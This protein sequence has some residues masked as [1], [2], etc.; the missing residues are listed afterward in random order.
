MGLK[1]FHKMKTKTVV[2]T[3]Q[4]LRLLPSVSTNFGGDLPPESILVKN[5]LEEMM[6]SMTTLTSLVNQ[7]E[8]PKQSEAAAFISS[9][10][11]SMQPFLK[12]LKEVLAVFRSKRKITLADGGALTTPPT[13]VPGVPGLLP[14]QVL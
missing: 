9:C 11:E 8:N 14:I 5:I 3:L 4:S 6:S 12:I 10:P 2:N 7:L 13:G 1:R